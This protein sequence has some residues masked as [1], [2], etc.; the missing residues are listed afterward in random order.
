M[1]GGLGAV[2][3]TT[4]SAAA[5]PWF[6][7]LREPAELAMALTRATVR[8]AIAALETPAEPGEADAQGRG[9]RG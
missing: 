2:S 5:D 8:H 9:R 7:D 4:G 3:A 6:A 1:N